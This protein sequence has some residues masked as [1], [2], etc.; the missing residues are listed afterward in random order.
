MS[1][2]IKLAENHLVPDDVTRYGIRRLLRKRLRKS[3]DNTSFHQYI[4]E[5]TTGP[6]ATEMDKANEQH[7]ML[8]PEFFQRVLG[9]NLKYS[10]CLFESSV[11]QLTDAEDLMLKKTCERAGI[12]DGM[13][14]LDVGCGW[15]SL[16]LYI[17]RKF[18]N[19]QIDSVSN[20]SEQKLFIE[21]RCALEGINSIQVTT[22]DINVFDPDKQFDRVVS[23]EMF[24]HTRNFRKLL[25]K[26]STWLL[27]EGKLFV[28]IFC[29]D[30]YTYLF[31]T[32]GDDNWMG[33]YFFTG[34]IMPSYTLLD[35]VGGKI[36][37]EKSWKVSGTH[38]AKTSRAWLANMDS[39][40]PASMELFHTTY[41]A[42]ASVW[43][44]RWR[45]FFMACEELFA[46]NHGREWFVG[47]YLMSP[48]DVSGT[49]RA[50]KHEQN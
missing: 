39:D 30:R 25:D 50:Y 47:H 22:A 6:I 18:P 8:P 28:H 24:E 19:C 46:F 15:G 11:N 12:K 29:H 43:F 45:M 37:M 44:Q 35:S 38:Y 41:G 17:A 48:S 23:V 9:D 1:L 4:N 31:E 32:E 21:K 33:R 20:S 10:C 27:P 3:Q 14:I 34:G 49:T 2:A 5:V 36:T 16:S 7:Y 13:K 42:Q 26:I 40:K